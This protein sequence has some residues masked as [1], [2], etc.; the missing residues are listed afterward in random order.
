M[1][2]AALPRESVPGRALMALVIF[3]V[4]GWP[5]WSMR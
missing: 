5:P 3:T 1:I 2:R 4:F